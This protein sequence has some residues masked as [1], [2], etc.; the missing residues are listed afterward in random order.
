MYGTTFGDFDI[1]LLKDDIAKLY[2]TISTYFLKVKNVKC[3][4]RVND[5]LAQQCIGRLL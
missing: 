3:Q 1:W 5:E 4:Y 2:S